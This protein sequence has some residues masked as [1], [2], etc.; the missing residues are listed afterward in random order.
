MA[1]FAFG[2][3]FLL[4][5]LAGEKDGREAPRAGND[6]AAGELFVARR[7]DLNGRLPGPIAPRR[8]QR[9]ESPAP[10]ANPPQA[11]SSPVAPAPE[12]AAIPVSAPAPPPAPAPAPAPSPEPS[13]QPEPS[14]NPEPSPQPSEPPS[15]FD[16]SG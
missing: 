10:P 5:R 15:S 9:A 11:P 8:H 2:N 6:Q 4:G 1:A 12:T 3:A 13:P 7:L 14:P 16:D